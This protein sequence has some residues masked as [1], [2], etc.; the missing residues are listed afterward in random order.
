MPRS[1]R[2]QFATLPLIPRFID[3]P[4]GRAWFD[5]HK[6]EYEAD[7]LIIAYEE[8]AHRDNDAHKPG[9]KSK[10]L[11]LEGLLLVV[12]VKELHVSGFSI[13]SAIKELRKVNQKRWGGYSDDVLRARYNDAKQHIERF[14]QMTALSA[15]Q[16]RLLQF[17]M[18]DVFAR[19]RR[20]EIKAVRNCGQ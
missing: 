20:A 10:W 6:A 5:W 3:M 7:C 4:G 2:K 1:K 14:F 15:P 18:D 12:A 11:H 9:P 13:V 17:R 8:F 16:W 19:L